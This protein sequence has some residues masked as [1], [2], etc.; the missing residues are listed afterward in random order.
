MLIY[1]CNAIIAYKRITVYAKG[2]FIMQI[3]SNYKASYC[4]YDVS[5]DYKGLYR[6]YIQ[7]WQTIQDLHYHSCA[8]FGLCLDGAGI[9]FVEDRIYPFSCGTVA[10]LP[11][12][13]VHIAQSPNERPSSWEYIWIDTSL[14]ESGMLPERETIIIDHD[15]YRL[16]NMMKD[17][18]INKEKYSDG[19]ELFKYL[20][21][22]ITLKLTRLGSKTKPESGE[23]SREMLLPAIVYI[24]E[25][26]SDNITISEL[27]NKCCV[28]IS[29]LRREFKNV[30]GM[31]PLEYIFTVK[32]TMAENL[33]E[34]T[35][36]PILEVSERSGF[37]V[38]SSF[39][40][41]FRKR[42]N[43]SPSEFRAL[44]KQL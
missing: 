3:R 30:T 4:P 41:Q 20:C 33:L 40:R 19:P 26:F 21:S 24:S 18:L 12:N 22:A 5:G 36:L 37:N 35:S 31:S 43:M 8:E 32:I 9:F 44:K 42:N 27:A 29:T 23:F 13:M 39:N 38:L 25:H 7:P 11:A 2:G 15:C 1:T 28:S 17:E 16:F 34:N 6:H 14:I 10:Y